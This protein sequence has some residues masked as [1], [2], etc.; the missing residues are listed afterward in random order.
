MKNDKIN[1]LLTISYCGSAY[2]GWQVQPSKKTIEGEVELAFFKLFN[3]KID[4]TGSGRTDAGVH[5]LKAKANAILPKE[6]TLKNF[7]DEKIKFEKLRNL[8]NH[9]LPEDIRVNSIKQ[10]ALCFNARKSAK[11]KTYLYKI[12]LGEKS[13]FDANRYYFFNLPLNVEHMQKCANILLGEHDF[14]SFCASKTSVTSFVRTI[15][16]IKI[17]Q[18]KDVITF[19]ICGNGFLYNMVRIIVGTLIDF[20]LKNKN[21]N[22]MR[23][24]LEAKNRNC[25]GKTAPACGLY[26][27]NVVY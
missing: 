15:Y 11:K 8:L 3:E 5:A 14:S 12:K 9:F 23:N 13:P 22:D 24:V 25:A 20:S 16:S 6:F 17:K 18:T 4:V 1:I 10:V 2:C 19:E 21:E 26:L 27:K 7:Y